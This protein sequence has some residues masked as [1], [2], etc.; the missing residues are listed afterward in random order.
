MSADDNSLLMLTMVQ[1]TLV[2]F[3]IGT[4]ILNVQLKLPLTHVTFG[5]CF[6]WSMAS[7]STS[8]VFMSLHIHVLSL[9][10]LSAVPQIIAVDYLKDME[11]V[12]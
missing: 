5:F 3:I 12:A 2:R 8:Y 7:T 1:T 6:V 11:T 10:G 4:S 9:H